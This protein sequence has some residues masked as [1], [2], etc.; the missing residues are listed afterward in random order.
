MFF[1]AS[2]PTGWPS[3]GSSGTLKVMVQTGQLEYRGAAQP[4][5]HIGP[6]QYT[7]Y[8]SSRA[9]RVLDY[10]LKQWGENGWIRS[11][12]RDCE[13]FFG[14][15]GGGGE[16]YHLYQERTHRTQSVLWNMYATCNWILSEISV[17]ITNCIA[18]S[19]VTFHFP[20]LYRAKYFPDFPAKFSGF[21]CRLFM[22]AGSVLPCK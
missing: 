14:G 21:I 11:W 5:N 22:F 17:S 20:A 1:P 4:K 3:R 18:K 13:H 15:G 19:T 8:W 7:P 2:Y 12:C 16:R 10:G 6:N 9:R